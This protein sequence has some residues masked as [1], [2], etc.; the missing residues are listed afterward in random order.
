MI[1]KVSDRNERGGALFAVAAWAIVAALAAWA[2]LALQPRSAAPADADLALFSAGRAIEHVRAIAREPRPA[3]SAAHARARAHIIATLRDLGLSPEVETGEAISTRYG[4]PFDSAN[5][6]NVTARIAGAPGSGELLLV[7]HYDT[8]PTSPGAADDG[9]G[10]AT[11]LETARALSAGPPPTATVVFLVTDAEEIGAVGAERYAAATGERPDR[12]VVSFDARGVRGPC[13][14]V[15]T[16]RGSGALVRALASVGFTPAATS[17]AP[18]LARFHGMGTDFRPFREAGSRGLNFVLVDGVAYYHTPRDDAAALDAGSLQQQGE[19]ALALAR[20]GVAG[21]APEADGIFFPIAGWGL[22]W[23]RMWVGL[24]AAIVATLLGLLLA[25]RMW[26]AREVRVRTLVAAIVGIVLTLVAAAAAGHLVWWSVRLLDPTWSAMQTADTYAPGAYRFAVVFAAAAVALAGGWL[27]VKR[28]GLRGVGLAGVALLLVLLWVSVAIA[29]GAL[30][31]VAIPAALLAV[32]LLLLERAPRSGPLRASI[33]VAFALPIVLLWAPVPYFVLVAL[34]LSAAVGAALA[35]A[36]GILAI[37][38]VFEAAELRFSWLP[39]V[40][41]GAAVA[42]FAYGVATAGFDAAAPRPVSLAFAE[43]G[44]TRRAFWIAA[45]DVDDAATAGYFSSPVDVA[46]MPA[47]F[48]ETN[49]V[50]R[51]SEAPSAGVLGPE[52]ALL[53]DATAEG[54]RTLSFRLKSRRGAPWIFAFLESRATVIETTIDGASASD[55]TIVEPPPDGVRWGFRHIGLRDEGI[56][57]TITLAASGD[58]VKIV[59][60]DQTSGISTREG[61]PLPDDLAFARSW[62]SGT[63][64]ARTAVAY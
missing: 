51:A 21:G 44:E 11:L 24:A 34:Q 19:I 56:V 33:A 22:V 7:A 8:V 64:L 46:S 42:C 12:V 27:V 32:A 50:E 2:V 4:L 49:T 60:V 57:W 48:A 58:P 3:G 20:T 61:A 13:G 55:A 38:L 15:E 10:V 37:L 26:R 17:L 43:D 53:G 62:V 41:A 14:L 59:V 9:S 18:A 52:V 47:F 63:T 54:R 35:A 31:L 5:V 16:G 6:A 39:A 45:G 23:M 30:Y 1:E 25:A 29:P 40:A 28:I 36:I